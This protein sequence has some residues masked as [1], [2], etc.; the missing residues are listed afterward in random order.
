MKTKELLLECKITAKVTSDYALA[1]VLD[2]PRQDIAYYMA[3]TRKPDAY[4]SVRIALCLR[5]D[6]AEVIATI[7]AEN[8]K[9]PKKQAFWVDFL[10]RVKTAARFGTLALLS[11]QLLLSEPVESKHYASHNVY[12]VKS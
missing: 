7:E 10:Q 5:K 4:A 2:I 1:K 9:N 12:Y 3:G 11:M 8:E 6:P